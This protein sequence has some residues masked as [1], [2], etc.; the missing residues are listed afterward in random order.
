ML[1]NVYPADIALNGLDWGA[2]GAFGSAD[3]RTAD[4]ILVWTGN[5]YTVYYLYDTGSGDPDWDNKW[6][7]VGNDDYPTTDSIPAG[8][9]FWYL[10]HGSW[11]LTLPNPAE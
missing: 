3:F 10:G 7:E 2:Q 6:Y 11:T 8:S 4:Q 9:G 5:G 1:A